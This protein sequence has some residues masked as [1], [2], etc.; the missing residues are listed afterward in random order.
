MLIGIRTCGVVPLLAFAC[1]ILPSAHAQPTGTNQHW[2]GYAILGSGHLTTVYS[3]DPRIIALT[4][5]RGLQHFYFRDYTADYVASTSFDLLNEKGAPQTPSGDDAIGMKNFFTAQTQTP[6]AKASSKTV[7]CFVHPDDVAVVSLSATGTGTRGRY[8]FEAVL[9]KDIQTDQHI[10]LTSL[11]EKDNIA[12]ATWSNGTVLAIVP[13]APH[14]RVSTTGRSIT[15]TGSLENRHA[16]AEVL[17]IPATSAADATVKARAFQQKADVE[18][19]TA[20]HW[21]A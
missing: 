17:L 16:A 6:L 13:K 2:K 14:D 20:K 9:R 21:N 8:K 3:D 7:L 18:A 4:H 12:L 11:L 19:E 1:A 15:V 10:T 5:Q